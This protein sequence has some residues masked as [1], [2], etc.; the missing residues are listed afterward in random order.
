MQAKIESK[1]CFELVLSPKLFSKPDPDILTSLFRMLSL[2]N[3]NVFHLQLV[4][5]IDRSF[6]H[7]TEESQ[8]VFLFVLEVLTANTSI[9]SVNFSSFPCSSHLVTQLADV[10]SANRFI[11]SLNLSHCALDDNC[12]ILL[13]R[14][15]RTQ[16]IIHTLDVSS[17]HFGAKGLTSLVKIIKYCSHLTV[18]SLNKLARVD[19]GHKSLFESLLHANLQSLSMQATNIT[20]EAG[21]IL[22]KVLLQIDGLS[23]LNISHN[24]LGSSFGDAFRKVIS[25]NSSLT[26]VNVSCCGIG[27][28]RSKW[29]SALRF[30]FSLLSLQCLDWSSRERSSF[31]QEI[32]ESKFEE[33]LFSLLERNGQY[34]QVWCKVSLGLVLNRRMSKQ[35]ED[36]IVSVTDTNLCKMKAFG[37]ILQMCDISPTSSGIATS[38]PLILSR[39]PFSAQISEEE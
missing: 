1:T 11:V 31:G 33:Q 3:C 5:E 25:T 12:M 4:E 2:Q 38:V 24:E 20:M 37:L 17:N 39:S 23:Y 13:S 15:L 14:G 18:L 21:L 36:L 19:S 9:V 35:H 22:C 34:N 32:E 30:N 26:H 8:S 10:F 28:R 27:D 6:S 7:R 16:G 29:I